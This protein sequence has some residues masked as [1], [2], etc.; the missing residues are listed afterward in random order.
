LVN[1]CPLEKGSPP[2]HPNAP[3]DPELRDILL[4]PLE[5]SPGSRQVR[6]NS[7]SVLGSVGFDGA[8]IPFDYR[9]YVLYGETILPGGTRVLTRF[10]IDTRKPALLVDEGNWYIQ[11][12]WYDAFEPEALELLGVSPDEARPFSWTLNVPIETIEEPPYLEGQVL[13]ART[14]PTQAAAM[15][16]A[17]S[18]ETVGGGP[19]TSLDLEVGEPKQRI[20]SCKARRV[21]GVE[22]GELFLT[23]HR[24][25]F[26]PHLSDHARGET[27]FL[28]R[29][30][31]LTDVGCKSVEDAQSG[32]GRK[33]ALRLSL[34][35]DREEIF[36]VEALVTVIERFS[37]AIHPIE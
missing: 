28:A 7:E 35:G 21:G 5:P 27:P 24:V 13:H 2:E 16:R 19:L 22:S 4:L 20:W 1:R 34:V 31:E 8:S 12:T 3:I 23:G 14:P 26:C 11:G 18:G 17:K 25:L 15:P 10:D 37:K 36:V 33:T 9:S 32:G 30:R 29:I 6:V